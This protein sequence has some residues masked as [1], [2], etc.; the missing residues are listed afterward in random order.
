MADT[1]PQQ[2]E[3]S[4]RRFLATIRNGSAVWGLKCDEGWAK[5][6]PR[7]D[8]AEAIVPFWSTIQEAQACARV[9]FPNY[10]PESLEA[11][12]F[13]NEWLVR[14]QDLGLFVGANLTPSMAGIDVRPDHIVDELGSYGG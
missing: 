4:Y 6:S 1:T 3:E 9:T 7:E 14:L 12:E 5:W 11:D 13:V 2:A 8:G 10:R